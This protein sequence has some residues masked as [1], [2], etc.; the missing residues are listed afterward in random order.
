MPQS[1]FEDSG[2]TQKTSAALYEIWAPPDS[3]WSPWVAPALFAQIECRDAAQILEPVPAVEWQETRAS[4]DTALIIDLPGAECVQF[5]LALAQIGYRPVLLINSSPGP[6][7]PMPAVAPSALPLQPPTMAPNVTAGIEVVDMR[8]LVAEVCG[9]SQFIRELALPG[10]APPAFVLDSS[11]LIGNRNVSEERFDNRW[12]VFPQDFPS[13]R[14]LASRGIVR[15]VAVQR[16][17]IDRLTDLQHVLLRWQ[18]AGI[19]IQSKNVADHGS[20]S[21]IIVPRPSSFRMAW[22]RALAILGFWRSNV[23]G[24]GSFLPTGSFGG[25]GFG[26]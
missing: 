5:A 10:D 24:F 16:G 11:R 9:R 17:D 26:G 12:M 19:E 6:I 13:A 25:F 8:A 3:P 20:P 14:F 21:K 1:L 23:G 7:G 4:R 2:L 15:A 22:Y 18:E